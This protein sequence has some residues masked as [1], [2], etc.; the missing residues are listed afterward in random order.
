MFEPDILTPAQFRDLQG[1]PMTQE[2]RLLLAMLEDA[3]HCYQ[4]YLLARK[5]HARQLF[6]DAEAWIH[7]TDVE[8]FFSFEN[9]CAILGLQAT[10][11]R[12]ALSKW[13]TEQLLLATLEPRGRRYPT[14]DETKKICLL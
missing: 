7:S 9:T 13:K 5:P 10:A 3:V 4:T 6:L 14:S 8:W 12:D 2:Q 11:L 1:K